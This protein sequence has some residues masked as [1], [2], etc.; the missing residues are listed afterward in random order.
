MPVCY[1]T[2]VEAEAGVSSYHE[3]EMDEEASMP[4]YPTNL[5]VES[6]DFYSLGTE[7]RPGMPVYY[8]TGLEI[9]N[10]TRIYHYAIDLNA[11]PAVP[12]HDSMGMEVEAS[13]PSE[14]FTGN[15]DITGNSTEEKPLLLPRLSPRFE[16]DARQHNPSP[17]TNTKEQFWVSGLPARFEKGA[18][19]FIGLKQSSPKSQ[20]PKLSKDKDDHPSNAESFIPESPITFKQ[21]S[22]LNKVLVPLVEE[23]CR[24]CTN[25]QPFARILL[26]W[27]TILETAT[28]HIIHLNVPEEDTN[29]LEIPLVSGSP[30]R[31]AGQQNPSKTNTREP[32]WVSGL[33]ARFEK[34]AGRFVGLKNSTFNTQKSI[35]SKIKDP[36]SEYRETLNHVSSLVNVLV[37]VVEEYCIISKKQQ[38]FARMLLPWATLL[39]I[40]T[41]HIIGLTVPEPEECGEA[42]MGNRGRILFFILVINCEVLYSCYVLVSYP[43]NNRF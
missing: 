22:S 27:V 41:Y 26:P 42:L 2:G 16:E 13:Q 20:K 9:Q 17:D 24:I 38:P 34:C 21:I 5:E 10:G 33:P 29:T 31:V 15:I 19:R 23:Y 40:A 6:P 35:F 4:G 3:T 32:L 36:K 1:S 14:Y 8:S 28:L 37:P 25:Q 7:E 11:K 39:E 30:T 43:T 12:A 18:G